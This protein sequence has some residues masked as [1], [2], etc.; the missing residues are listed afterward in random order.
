MGTREVDIQVVVQDWLQVVLLQA[1]GVMK[2]VHTEAIGKL[3]VPV[4]SQ[5]GRQCIY[6]L[7]YTDFVIPVGGFAIIQGRIGMLPRS[8]P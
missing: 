8:Q 5:L 3:P 1:F 7:N 4:G 2:T 6:Q